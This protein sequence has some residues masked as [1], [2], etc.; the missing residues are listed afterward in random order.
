MPFSLSISMEPLEQ[1][2]TEMTDSSQYQ[3]EAIN[4]RIH[5]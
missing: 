4:Q 1:I 5:T 3:Y 2:I